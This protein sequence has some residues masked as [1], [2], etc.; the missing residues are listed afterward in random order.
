MKD[1]IKCF[2][3]HYFI[4]FGFFDYFFHSP[5]P[6]SYFLALSLSLSLSLPLWLSDCNINAFMIYFPL[7]GQRN[8]AQSRIYTYGIRSVHRKIHPKRGLEPGLR[9]RIFLDGRI[10][11]RAFSPQ[12]WISGIKL[13]VGNGKFKNVD[14]RKNVFFIDQDFSL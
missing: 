6:S 8:S 3:A 5:F 2:F 7:G 12:P 4:L 9:I 13:L 1:Q 14:G 10:Q 11:V